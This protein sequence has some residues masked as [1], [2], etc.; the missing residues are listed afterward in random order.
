MT[1]HCQ[2][3]ST[4]LAHAG[5][6]DHRLRGRSLFQDVLGRSSFWGLWS[7]ALGGPDLSE[8]DEQVLCAL[9]ICN[10]AADPRIPPMKLIRLLA[11]YGGVMAG[12]AGGLAYQEEA[13][14]GT[15]TLGRAAA[16]L[17]QLRGALGTN[18]PTR[19]EENRKAIAEL[20]R[21]WLNRGRRPAGFGVPARQVDERVI[22]LRTRMAALDR[23]KRPFWQLAELMEEV[24]SVERPLPLNIAGAAGAA[25]LDMGF[26]P[27]Q[28]GVLAIAFAQHAFV[29]NALEGADSAPALLQ[30]LPAS[31]VSYLGPPPRKSP[32]ALA[33]E[34]ASK[35]PA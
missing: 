14:I 17:L 13:L 28:I 7:T 32:R 12:V 16:D 26:Q 34:P 2:P 24:L 3:L 20:L 30:R 29:G 35:P 21:G 1:V 31:A 19:P 9:A 15:W 23:N 18:P 4:R 33:A 5:W 10:T 27:R 25:C 11:S 6:S 8:Q 22:A